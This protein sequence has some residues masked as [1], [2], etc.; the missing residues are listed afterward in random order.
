M[1]DEWIA[2]EAFKTYLLLPIVVIFG[3][4]ILSF[5]MSFVGYEKSQKILSFGIYST[6]ISFVLIVFFIAMS[7]VA[8]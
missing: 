8:K 7:V 2:N 3:T 6:V 5:L 4:I 1:T